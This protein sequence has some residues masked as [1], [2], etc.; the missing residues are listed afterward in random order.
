MKDKEHIT[1]PRKGKLW[2]TFACLLICNV[3]TTLLVMN[4]YNSSPSTSISPASASTFLTTSYGGP[5]RFDNP[6]LAF[7]ILSELD[8]FEFMPHEILA[9]MNMK[10]R[11]LG[12]AKED[13]YCDRSRRWFTENG[14][15]VFL[16]KNIFTDTVKSTMMRKKVISKISKDMHPE[17][18]SG[19]PASFKT[20]GDLFH[21]RPD[22]H[23]Y[24]VRM[25]G[26]FHYAYTFSKHFGCNHQMYNHIYG[27]AELNKKSQFAQ[28]YQ[29]YIW[30]NDASPQCVQEFMPES[31]LLNRKVQCKIFFEYL[32]SEE[33]KAEKEKNTY[34]FFK[35]K[36]AAS[37]A[38]R[39]VFLFNEESEQELREEYKNG[40]K[41]GEVKKNVQMQRYIQ[42]PLLLYGHKFDFRVYML[43]VSL[44]PLIVYY[45]DGFLK[46]SLHDY[47]RNSTNRAAHL[48]NTELSK[49]IFQQARNGGWNGMNETEV[50]RFQT[51]MYSRLHS[52][53]LEQNKTTDPNWLDTSLRPQMQKI[54]IHVIR[55]ASHGFVRRS[56]IYEL[57]GVDFIIDDNLKVWFIEANSSPSFESTT[58]ERE[59]LLVGML[60]DHFDVVFAYLKSRVKRIITFVNKV[61][62]ALPEDHIFPNSVVIPNFNEV[63]AQYDEINKNYLDPEYELPKTNGFKKIMDENLNGPERYNGYLPQECF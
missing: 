14:G 43:I 19:L 16:R 35:K 30:K 57:Y 24:E 49:K 7:W 32:D 46:L 42:S 13:S 21:L 39:G 44:N 3:A 20:S 2:Q 63:K 36:G 55:A 27:G 41:C 53:L 52:Y 15:V 60:S 5:Y 12:F 33:Y 47:S 6:T 37:H 1:I 9:K 26:G 28:N 62:K 45:H 17:V 18:S 58:K 31:Y 23:S 22:I 48:A 40:K 50:R 29:E 10:R 59:K 11:Y 54:M 8:Q 61:A 51:W 38:G 4:I 56:N 34:V 25:M